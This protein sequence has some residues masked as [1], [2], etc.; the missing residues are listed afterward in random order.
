MATL[1]D[2]GG[3]APNRGE[4]NG[5]GYEVVEDFAAKQFKLFRS[6]AQVV[7]GGGEVTVV[8]TEGEVGTTTDPFPGLTIELRPLEYPVGPVLKT[9]TTNSEGFYYF[10]NLAAGDYVVKVVIPEGYEIDPD[11]NETI[12]VTLS[13]GEHASDKDFILIQSE[14]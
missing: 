6:A 12:D 14:L 5:F 11:S 3:P 10:D 2:L 13:A 7:A 4:I 8:G 9:D 1:A